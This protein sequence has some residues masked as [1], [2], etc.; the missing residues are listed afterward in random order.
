MHKKRGFVVP[1]TLIFVSAIV[2]ITGILYLIGSLTVS[3]HRTLIAREKARAV[4]LGGVNIA[5]SMLAQ[6][7]KTKKKDAQKTADQ[8][9]QETEQSILAEFLIGFGTWQKFHFEA[10]RDGFAGQVQISFACEEG[11]INLNKIYD[12][13]KHEFIKKAPWRQIVMD[14]LKRVQEKLGGENI[15]KALEEYLAKRTEPLSDVTDL[16]T[17]KEFAIFK[18]KVFYE[19]ST[20]RLPES[21]EGKHIFLTDLFTIDSNS[22]LLNGFFASESL[23]HVFNLSR[24]GIVGKDPLQLANEVFK[25]I[26]NEKSP[27]TI[28]RIFNKIYGKGLQSLPKTIESVLS[29]SFEP[30]NF[31][32]ITHGTVGAVTQRLVAILVRQRVEP[33]AG[34][35]AEECYDV[36]IKKLYWL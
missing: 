24:A 17:I 19:P 32:I 33:A 9:Q 27:Q 13:K 21:Q 3:Y 25:P 34:K 31:Y 7:C 20:F 35:T 2:G 15:F 18:E 29:T 26:A 30:K 11:K 14:V 8:K 10:A 1:V 28:E 4:A 16:L 6:P 23:V 36:G 22:D 12:F 5:M